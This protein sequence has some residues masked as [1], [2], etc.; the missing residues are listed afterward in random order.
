MHACIIEK[1]EN[2]KMSAN[3]ESQ[4]DREEEEEMVRR[5]GEEEGVWYKQ[6]RGY[7]KGEHGGPL[8]I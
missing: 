3:R 4:T 7:E 6:L 2:I 1:G 8:K 5:V